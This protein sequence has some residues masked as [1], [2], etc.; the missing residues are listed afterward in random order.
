M[1]KLFGIIA[2]ALMTLGFMVRPIAAAELPIE[3]PI[4]EEVE[5]TPVY[6]EEAAQFTEDLNETLA[7]VFA[8]VGG[9]SGLAAIAAFVMRYIRERNVMLSIKSKIDDLG[10]QSN[11]NTQTV[12]SLVGV[13]NQYSSKEA[14]LEKMVISLISV[15]N[16][17]PE[18]KKALIEG[19]QNDTI[20]AADLIEI[21]LEQVAAEVQIN[22]EIKEEINKNTTSLL[23][24]LTEKD[25]A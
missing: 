23:K 16:L 14:M 7:S 4:V 2:L 21:G 9:F 15:S 19:L 20:Q 3:D 5:E 6:E 8:W 25:N 22:Q 12:S 1:K 18:S 10:N 17:N 24:K 11:T 13:V